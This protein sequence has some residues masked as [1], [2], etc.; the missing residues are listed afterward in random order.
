MVGRSVNPVPVVAALALVAVLA[1]VDGRDGSGGGAA[2]DPPGCLDAPAAE[3]A[4]DGDS[5][6]RS[7]LGLREDEA[8]DRAAAAGFVVRL[9]RR[10]EECFPATADHREDRVDLDLAADGFVRGARRG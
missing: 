8:R 7:L 2:A 10:G 6:V 5:L 3:P 4:A 9:V 1:V